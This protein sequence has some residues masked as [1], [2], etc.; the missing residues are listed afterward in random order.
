MVARRARDLVGTMLLLGAL[1][2]LGVTPVAAADCTL[3]APSY[4]NVGSE[5]TI[6]GSGFPGSTS[7]DIDLA[8]EGGASDAFA[9]Q[10]DAAGALQI[11]MVPEDIDIGVTTVQ[12]T[13]GTACTASVTYTVLA[14]GA[15]PPPAPT[16]EPGAVTGGEPTVPST[17]TDGWAGSGS[18]STGL[19]WVLALALV[20]A[21]SAGLFLTRSP[22]QR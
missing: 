10:T 5:L 14:A 2:A 17:D 20:G 19:V 11:A 15:T 6:D 7:V 8:I 13:A 9:V 16:E 12:A 3:S 21:G 4:V 1:T 18:G 22:R